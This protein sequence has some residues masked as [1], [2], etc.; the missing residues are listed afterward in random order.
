MYSV[1]DVAKMLNVKEETVRRWI[2]SGKLKANRAVGRGGNTLALE[3]IIDFAN[4]SSKENLLSLEIWLLE[5]GYT[6]KEIENTSKSNEHS[7]SSAKSTLAKGTVVGGA[8]GAGSAAAIGAAGTTAAVGGAGLTSIAGA[9]LASAALGPIGIGVAGVAGLAYVASK[10]MKQKNELNYSI[11]LIPTDNTATEYANSIECTLDS[12]NQNY[13]NTEY[14]NT[15]TTQ[16]IIYL[17]GDS[18]TEASEHQ[19]TQEAS[20]EAQDSPIGA[21]PSL[22]LMDEIARAKQLLDAEIITPE[23]FAEIKAKLIAR[24]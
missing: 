3:D 12:I 17:G 4:N 5:H 10:M 1:S 24:I 13:A 8:L 19:N 15:T 21:P 7:K 14:T 9:G 2:R 11:Q 6:Y 20:S 22:G 18:H 23:E 16:D